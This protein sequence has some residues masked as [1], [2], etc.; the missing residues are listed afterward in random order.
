[1]EVKAK[2]RYSQREAD[3]TIFEGENNTIIVRFKEPQRAPTP[4]QAVV[5]YLDNIILGG[6]TIKG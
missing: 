4:G 1:M 2:S 6:G 5:F 3:A